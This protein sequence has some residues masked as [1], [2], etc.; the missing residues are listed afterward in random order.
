MSISNKTLTERLME[1]V[2]REARSAMS[3]H[4]HAKDICKE[5]AERLIDLDKKLDQAIDMLDCN[6]RAWLLAEWSKQ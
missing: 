4:P 2:D 5:A 3:I 6:G 1:E